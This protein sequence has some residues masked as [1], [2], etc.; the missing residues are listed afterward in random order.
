MYSNNYVRYQRVSN[1]SDSFS[2]GFW[3]EFD[4]LPAWSCIPCLQI[5]IRWFKYNLLMLNMVLH[6]LLIYLTV[7]SEGS[8]ICVWAWKYAYHF[9]HIVEMYW[10][11]MHGAP[12]PKVWAFQNRWKP[13]IMWHSNKESDSRL[14]SG[15][16]E[17]GYIWPQLWFNSFLP[18]IKYSILICLI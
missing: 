3:W 7:H 11:P 9:R 17:Q 10:S 8:T 16:T 15:C 5:F 12:V 18:I 2:T 13:C 4:H 1:R 14:R 6:P